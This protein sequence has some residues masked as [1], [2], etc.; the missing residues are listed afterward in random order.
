MLERIC[1]PP[2]YPERTSFDLGLLAETLI[3]YGEV[4]LIVRAP[5]LSGLLKQCSPETLLR[6]LDHGRLKIKYLNNM[7]GAISRGEDTPYARYDFGLISSQKQNLE[8]AAYTIFRE[9]TGKSGRGRRLANRFLRFV[10][11]ISYEEDI[12]K[13]ITREVQDGKYISEYIERRLKKNT[14]ISNKNLEKHVVF[15]FGPLA[16]GGLPLQ[17]NIKFGKLEKLN[18]QTKELKNPSSILAHYGT[19]ITDLSLWSTFDTEV[20]VNRSEADVLQSRFDVILS[21]RDESHEV[22]RSFQDFVFDDGRAIRNAINTGKRSLDEL[23]PIVERSGKFNEWLRNQPVD[24]EIIKSYYK[25]VTSDS[26][27]DKLPGKTTR[28]AIFTGTGLAIDSLGGG[29]IGTGIGI[30]L[31]ALDHFVVDKLIKGWKP[32]QFIHGELQ[33]FVER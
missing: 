30:A 25:E 20:A 2:K 28:W 18:L 32:N 27:V 31:S 26:W 16:E 4:L 14:E 6:F 11:P 10:E 15:Q 21:R 9:A 29:G 33:D 13:E 17:T 5:S 1:I 3:F 24:K 23:F 19:T 8:N 22:V 7:L 12:A